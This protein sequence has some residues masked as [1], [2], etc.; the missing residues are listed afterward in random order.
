MIDPFPFNWFQIVKLFWMDGYGPYV[1][2]AWGVAGAGLAIVLAH[3]LIDSERTRRDLDRIR[4]ELAPN[5]QPEPPPK[6][7]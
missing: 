2:T 7:N 4:R 1:W 6:G 3:V 5:G